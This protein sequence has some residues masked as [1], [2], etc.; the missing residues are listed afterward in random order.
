MTA[1]GLTGW[2]VVFDLDGTLVDTAPD[3]HA[4]LNHCL[5][6]AGL[7]PVPFDAIRGMI[8]EGAR[9]M[10][11]KGIAWNEADERDHDG[12]A[13]WTAF[14]EHYEANICRLSR[15][16]PG[17][18]ASLDMLIEAGAICAVCT[19]KTQHLADAVLDTLDLSGKFAAII[20]A[21]SVPAKKPDGDHI[22]Q[23]IARAGGRADKAIMIGDSQTDERAARDAGLPFVFVGF[24]YG[25]DPEDPAGL[26][27][28]NTYEEV[29]AAIRSLA[30]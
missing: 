10:I 29:I 15:P 28:A 11:R 16:F 6:G 3:L 27:F 26:Y 20:G 2:T 18:V 8:G 23:T 1:A 4:S 5:E 30:A 12:D 19:N 14:L 9:A 21:D 7:A 13:L 22:V 17:A 24:G 25:P